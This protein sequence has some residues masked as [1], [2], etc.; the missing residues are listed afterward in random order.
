MLTLI[1]LASLALTALILALG[2]LPRAPRD[3]HCR[4]PWEDAEQ[5]AL[6]SGRPPPPPLDFDDVLRGLGADL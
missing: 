2:N 3:H 1:V 5:A 6:V 4:T